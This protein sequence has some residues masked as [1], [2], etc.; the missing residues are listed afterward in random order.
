MEFIRAPQRPAGHFPHAAAIEETGADGEPEKVTLSVDVEA[1]VSVA[2]RKVLL[3]K[4]RLGLLVRRHLVPSRPS[5]CRRIFRPTRTPRA[6][7]TART[8]RA[9]PRS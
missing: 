8:L 3:D 1:F 2:W 4:A 7:V 6:N 9:S 5:P